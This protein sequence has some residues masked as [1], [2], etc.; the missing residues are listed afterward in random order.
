MVCDDDKFGSLE[1][2]MLF[3]IMIGLDVWRFTYCVW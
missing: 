2:C 3:V 1:V